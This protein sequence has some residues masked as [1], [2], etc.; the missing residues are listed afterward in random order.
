[1]AV[2]IQQI[3]DRTGVSRGTVDRALNG[4]GRINKEVAQRI[5]QTA[6][7][8]G[9]VR[10]KRRKPGFRIGIVTQLAESPFM[11]EVNRGIREAEKQLLAQ[12]VKIVLK[13]GLLVD[14]KEQLKVLEQ[15]E[16]EGIDALAVMPADSEAIR[17]KL[18]QMIEKKGI[19][20]VTFNSDIIGTKRSC[21]VGLDNHRSGRAAAGLMSQMNKERGRML[22]IT[23]YFMNR[24]SN[25]RVDG[26]VGEI[27]ESFPGLELAGVHGSFDNAEEVENIIVKAMRDM[28]DITGIFVIS[29]GQEGIRRAFEKLRLKKRPHTII[30]D[31]TPSNRKLLEEDV[32]DFLIDQEAFAQGYRPPL[33]L[34]EILSNGGKAKKEFYY[35]DIVIKTKYNL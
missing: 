23:G 9:Y 7:E 2:T 16:S 8:M 5:C 30:Y 13:E 21:Y 35:T 17:S 25:S 26:F 4:R 3:A 27:K 12:N 14:E 33:I 22:V 28:P 18:D 24:V 15:L 19:P 29:G 34:A 6:E 10:K 31:L 32:V 11:Q 1:M 20:V